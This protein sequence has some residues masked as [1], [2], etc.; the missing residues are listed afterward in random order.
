MEIVFISVCLL[1]FLVYFIF[2]RGDKRTSEL[3]NKFPGPR[4]LPFI[5]N[6]LDFNVKPTEML[7]L[8]ID[9]AKKWPKRF[10][11][12]VGERPYLTIYNP[13]DVEV[14]LSSKIQIDKS[15]EYH[16]FDDWLGKGLLTSTG[17]KWRSRR[18]MLTPAF[19]YHL[20][21][22]FMDVFNIQSQILVERLATKVDNGSFD[23][24]PF[25]SCCT[26]DI[27]CDSVMGQSVNAQINSDSAYVRA[28]D[29]MEYIFLKRQYNVLLWPDFIFYLS[30]LGRE[31]TKTVKIIHA[32]SDKI[33]AERK[34][35]YANNSNNNFSIEDNTRFKKKQHFT[36]LDILLQSRDKD[37][38]LT[39]QEIRNEVDTFMA[40]GNDSAA[41]GLAWTVFLLGLYTNIQKKAQ[42]ELDDVLGKDNKFP[43]TP[44]D[45]TNLKYLDC[46]IKESHRIFP[47]VPMILRTLNQDVILDGKTVPAGVTI[48]I[49]IY[50]LHHNPEIYP[51]P[52][53][54]N[55]DRFL[56][57][58]NSQ[59]NAFSFIPFSAGPRNCIGQKYS[60]LMEKV[61]MANLLRNYTIESVDRMEDLVLTGQMTLRNEHGIPIRLNK[62]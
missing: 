41:A 42:K 1:L 31:Q 49:Q 37:D 26:L 3:T 40:A 9:Y 52:E 19:K 50:L 5:G 60:M 24:Y 55:P 45:L 61:I 47:P 58:C 34:K 17:H 21:D 57:E 27:L 22:S 16:Y 29:K 28:T 10:R 2:L 43:I 12:W 18:K 8:Y 32:F 14:I 56:A 4:T 33:I 54:F 38:S 7:Q 62:R 51:D 35:H 15:H 46:I 59:I 13:E 36:F 11:Y 23:V 48:Q 39:D 25:I 44:D 30:P 6:S 53:V 20:L